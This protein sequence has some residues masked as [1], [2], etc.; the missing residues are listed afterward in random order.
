MI[1]DAVEELRLPGLKRIKPRRFGD[2]RGYFEEVFNRADFERFGLPTH[3][4]QDNLSFSHKGTIRGMHF[5]LAPSAQAKLVKVLQ[6][7]ILDVVIDIRPDSA[8]FGQHEVVELSDENGHL[9]LVPEG[10]AHGFEALE[11]TLFLYKCSDL[12]NPA[13]EGGLLYNDPALGIEWQTVDPIVSPKDLALP[14]FEAW[15]AIRTEGE[16]SKV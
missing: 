2:L 7:R 5:Q 9:L 4:P 1:I 15:K 6:G 8:T 14:G 13:A 12:Y 11:D 16:K 3:F 10:F